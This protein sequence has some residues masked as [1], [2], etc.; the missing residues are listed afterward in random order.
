[1]VS[2]ENIMDNDRSQVEQ[3]AGDTVRVQ[4]WFVSFHQCV[5]QDSRIR[6]ASWLCGHGLDGTS[7][8]LVSCPKIGMQISLRSVSLGFFII[9]AFTDVIG[10]IRCSVLV[11]VVHQTASRLAGQAT[12]A[13]AF[14]IRLRRMRKV[15]PERSNKLV[16]DLFS[17]LV[18]WQLGSRLGC[19]SM[20][21]LFNWYTA[22]LPG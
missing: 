18:I 4:G 16:G 8:R 5:K 12:K 21:P 1:M 3:H 22:C 10:A 2:P 15:V 9:K 19:I 7:I 11:L 14:N 13:S 20:L 6:H 17:G